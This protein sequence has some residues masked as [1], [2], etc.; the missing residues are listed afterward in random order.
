[1]LSGETG[2]QVFV[3]CLALSLFSFVIRVWPRKVQSISSSSG[4]WE[5]LCRIGVMVLT[6]FLEFKVKALRPGVLF[7]ESFIKR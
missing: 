6:C 7:G 2:L 1:M 4:V 5:R 3:V